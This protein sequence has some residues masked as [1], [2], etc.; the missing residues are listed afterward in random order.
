VKLNIN[1]V[2]VHPHL[3]SK[4]HPVD[5]ALVGASSH[6]LW[7]RGLVWFGGLGWVGLGGGGDGGVGGLP[8]G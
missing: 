3:S 1:S 7:G 6:W 5:G 2:E 8:W 4:R